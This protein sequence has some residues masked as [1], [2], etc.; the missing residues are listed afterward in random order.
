MLLAWVRGKEPC[1]CL[2]FILLMA[3]CA[4]FARAQEIPKAQG[5]VPRT[6]ILPQKAVAGAPAT[7]AVLDAAGR[8]LP[9]VAVELSDGQTVTTNS[10]GRAMFVVPRDPGTLVAKLSRQGI[11]ASS[12]VV[13]SEELAAHT[14]P[15]GDSARVRVTSYP[16]VLAIHD[17]FTIQGA[18]FRGAADLT[19]VFL[20]DQPCLVVASSPISLV[21]LPGPHLPIGAIALRV[22]VDGHDTGR[23]PVTAVLLEFS[24]PADV[25]NAGTRGKLILRVRGTTD[26]LAVEVRNGSPSIIQ[27]P[28]GNMQRLGT[29]EG[30]ENFAPVELK[31]LTSGNYTISARLISTDSGSPS[32]KN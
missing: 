11:T 13:P 15:E 7:L 8:L 16:H 1:R 31:F 5:P 17:R 21:V 14:P 2:A 27:L 6:I 22:S 9:G 18:G 3:G 20:D 19:R 28:G 30:E 25:P 24:S 32:G 12:T 26:R 23:I 29:S 4:A 10:T